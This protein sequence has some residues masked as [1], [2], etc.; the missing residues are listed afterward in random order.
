MALSFNQQLLP[1][2]GVPVHEHDWPVDG[3]ITSDRVLNRPEVSDL[4][5]SFEQASYDLTRLGASLCRALLGYETLRP[6]Q[7]VT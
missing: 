1:A 2:D 4:K 7:D 6:C 5:K 3:I